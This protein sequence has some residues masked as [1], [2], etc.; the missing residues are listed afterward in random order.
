MWVCESMQAPQR[1]FL[2]TPGVLNEEGWSRAGTQGFLRFSGTPEVWGV[3]GRWGL[4]GP[5]LSCQPG[6]P[7]L[8]S[9]ALPATAGSLTARELCGA[10]AQRQLKPQDHGQE[11]LGGLRLLLLLL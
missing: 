3:G 10:E 5:G 8:P 4:E 2:G 1:N 9:Q 7:T 11:S 6:S